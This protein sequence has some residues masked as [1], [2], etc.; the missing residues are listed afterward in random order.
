MNAKDLMY[1][2]LQDKGITLKQYAKFSGITEGG[3][4]VAVRAKH[5]IPNLRTFVNLVELCGYEVVVHPVKTGARAKGQILVEV[6][7]VKKQQEDK[8]E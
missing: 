3:A 7:D 4:W 2:L 8:K 6:P 1:K 5:T